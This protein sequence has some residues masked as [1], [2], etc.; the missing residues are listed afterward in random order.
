MRTPFYH[1]ICFVI[2]LTG[3]S[4]GLNGQQITQ[5][6][7]FQELQHIWNPAFTAPDE[8]LDYS[9]YYRKQ[10]IGFEGAP[11]TAVA[12]VEIPFTNL[13]MSAG[14]IV[15]SDWTGQVNKTGVQLNY[16]YKIK[17]LI[18]RDDQLSLA[19][20]GFF[21]QYRFDATTVETTVPDDPRV[22]TMR[23]SKFLPSFGAGLAYY[24]STKEYDG[25]NLFY[26]GISS[27]QLLATNIL[28]T[29][30]NAQR[31]RHYYL[32]MGT[33]LFGYNHYIEPSFQ[34]NYVNPAIIYYLVGAKYEMR[35][36]FWM[37]LSYS[38]I[39]NL[40]VDG[41]I[42]LDNISG[43]QTRLKLG[44]LA[45]INGGSL[46]Q[47]GASFEFYAAYTFDKQ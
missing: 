29:D 7:P 25:E 24:S 11:N 16:A 34:I 33:K 18:N 23:Q 44:A 15:I 31:E 5:T 3:Y 13:N 9:L 40:A 39:N 43:S 17:N 36:T 4:F 12:S 35:E 30:G 38:N 46:M 26:V 6:S 1:N 21:Y 10:W 8:A 32:N 45:S 41:G 42:I 14:G 27:M 19:L 20:N 28:L 2:I 47:T 37:G 22:S